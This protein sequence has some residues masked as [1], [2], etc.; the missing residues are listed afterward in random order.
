MTSDFEQALQELIWERERVNA[1]L[2]TELERTQRIANA[3]QRLKDLNDCAQSIVVGTLERIGVYPDPIYQ[4]EPFPIPNAAR[5]TRSEQTAEA[6][7]GTR[8]N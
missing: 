7:Y 3:A 5:P 2:V 4:H 1:S 8:P 6:L